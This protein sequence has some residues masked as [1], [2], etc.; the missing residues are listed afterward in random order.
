MTTPPT[1]Q[2]RVLSTLN[3]DGSR[4]W[5]NPKLSQGR[6]LRYRRLVAYFLMLLFVFL[7]HLRWGGQP[8][9][10][11]DLTTRRFH[12][13][14]LTFFPTDTIL[15]L[16][17]L[18]SI[19]LSIFL[20]TALF[21][22]VWCGWAC[23][24]TV[25]MEFL[26][27]PIER[28]FDGTPAQQR[29]RAEE[30]GISL[31]TPLKYLVYFLLA[32]LLANSFLAYFIGTEKLWVWMRQSPLTHP[33]AFLVMAGT[34]ALIFFDFAYFREQTC[35]VACPYGRFQ[36]ALL[37]R[38]SLI[39]GYDMG[40]GE[41][42]GKAAQ[43][44]KQPEGIEEGKA[45]GDCIDCGACVVT[46]PTGIDIRDGLQMECIN[47]TQCIDACDEI[48][49]KIGKP[50]GLIRYTSQEELAGG[51]KMRLLRPRTLI[52]PMLILVAISGFFLM[53]RR[54][55]I[56][57]ADIAILRAGQSPFEIL[58]GA[59]ISSQIRINISNRAA[60]KRSYHLQIQGVD[61]KPLQA[62]IPRNPLVIEP[63][64]ISE[65]NAFVLVPSHHYRAGRY[66]IRVTIDDKQGF[67]QERVYNL[68][69]PQDA[70]GTTTQPS[71]VPPQAT[72]RPAS[73]PPQLP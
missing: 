15:L 55:N 62:I 31:R 38:N 7:P 60:Q 20:V 63:F 40:R 37:D 57:H 25:Y 41:A 23:P 42:R 48:M 50:T 44:K 21:G 64:Q 70:E 16:F 22:R 47:C 71:S 49:T 26:F 54:S 28:F 10:L 2:E 30:G 29:K 69:G 9:I 13:F 58:D 35:L 17:F 61:G 34:T 39:V 33:S 52:Y 73:R 66:S 3:K 18:L 19:F 5:I 4:R 27:R 65:T 6:F 72:S 24:Q 11:L 1:T 68:L 67:R 43:R 32:A 45:W 8:L 53:L 59:R 46:C 36:S 51:A 12:I 56:Q 14:G